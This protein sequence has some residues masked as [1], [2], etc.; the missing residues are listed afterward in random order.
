MSHQT[1]MGLKITH[2][3]AHLLGWYKGYVYTW[4]DSNTEKIMVGFK[5]SICG[6]ISGIEETRF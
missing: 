1:E 4:I 2:K 6:D 3:V 5:C